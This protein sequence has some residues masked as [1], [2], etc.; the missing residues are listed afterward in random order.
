MTELKPKVVFWE[1]TKA[2][3]LSCIHCSNESGRQLE[4]ELTTEEVKRVMD[5]LM[6]LGTEEL[7]L[8]GGE[9]LLRKDLFDIAHY[10]KAQ[11]QD[12]YL[13]LYTNGT[14]MTPAIFAALSGLKFNKIYL[15]IHD[16]RPELHD[17]VTQSKG[18]L[19]R[20]V[21]TAQQLQD[22]NIGINYT[23]SKLNIDGVRTTFA[24]A[25]EELN[26]DTMHVSILTDVGRAAEHD[27]F[28]L[29][30]KDLEYLAEI[31]SSAY[32]DYFGGQ[33]P[34]PC[35]AAA[36]RIMLGADGEVYPCPLFIEPE[37]SAGNI[38][39]SSFRDIWLNP[40]KVFLEVR[41]IILE[42]GPDDGCRSRAYYFTGDLRGPDF[43]W[44]RV[45]KLKNNADK[46]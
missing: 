11:K 1:A 44:N 16:F 40:K 31:V 9:P 23:I 46:K 32:T 34:R 24:F 27:E 7:R 28:K 15:S 3:N 20:V 12:L 4:N 45:K 19:E 25:K 13:S 29:T 35:E 26:A 10:A 33:Q 5:D 42:S 30:R 22:F 14:I 38:R 18:S 41:N 8:Y 36:T 2:C 6:Q 21:K 37:F 17:S 39:D 43:Y